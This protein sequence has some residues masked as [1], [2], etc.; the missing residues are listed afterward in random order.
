MHQTFSLETISFSTW[1]FLA[2]ILYLALLSYSGSWYIY[3]SYFLY[4]NNKNYF[5]LYL[6]QKWGT[7]YS[8]WTIVINSRKIPVPRLVLFVVRDSLNIWKRYNLHKLDSTHRWTAPSFLNHTPVKFS[9]S[10]FAKLQHH[11]FDKWEKKKADCVVVP[12]TVSISRSTHTN[13]HTHILTRWKQYQPLYCNRQWR[14][15]RNLM[16]DGSTTKLCLKAGREN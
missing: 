16:T 11:H 6:W 14:H 1:I 13:T 12:S 10:V 8:P 7:E 3:Y 2:E 4:W 5:F 15:G 9:V